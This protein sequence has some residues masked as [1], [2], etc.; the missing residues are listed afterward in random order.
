MVC[1]FD[2]AGRFFFQLRAFE[3]LLVL[4]H[5]SK[6]ELLQGAREGRKRKEER[7][8]RGRRGGA[9]SASA[10]WRKR[11]KAADEKRL[12]REQKTEREE[13]GLK[14]TDAQADMQ[15]DDY[16]KHGRHDRR[17]LGH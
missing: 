15:P 13:C 7:K 8:A 9:A 12:A 17:P 3:E 6:T 16:R 5:R 1:F 2:A 14:Q 11:R 4:C 10:P